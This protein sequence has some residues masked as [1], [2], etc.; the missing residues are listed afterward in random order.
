[1]SETRGAPDDPVR[2]DGSTRPRPETGRERIA[3]DAPA[4]VLRA[5]LE[6]APGAALVLDRSYGVVLANEAMARCFGVAPEAMAGRHSL[7]FAESPASREV[8]EGRLRVADEVFATG[9]G[10]PFEVELGG[11]LLKNRMEP[12]RDA[13]VVVRWRSSTRPTSPRRRRS[14]GSSARRSPSGRRS[15]TASAR[16]SRPSTRRMRSSS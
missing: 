13:D 14:R 15:R 5:L 4:A 10:V 3:P 6:A 12:L 2:R 7:D 11:R 1:M 9:R 8:L 16:G